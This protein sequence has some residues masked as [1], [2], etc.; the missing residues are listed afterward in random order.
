MLEA[1]YAFSGFLAVGAYL[2][3]V[4]ELWKGKPSAS[5]SSYLIWVVTTSIGFLY[6][7]IKIQDLLMLYVYAAHLL[8]CLIILILRIR[9]SLR[10]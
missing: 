3:T 8:L 1:L 6:V 7:V 5:T 2:P 10:K 9:L 4:Y